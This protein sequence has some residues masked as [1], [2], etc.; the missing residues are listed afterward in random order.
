MYADA[1]ARNVENDT[2]LFLAV[3]SNKLE[4]VK[5][6]AE[7]VNNH[8]NISNV[9]GQ[10]LPLLLSSSIPLSVQNCPHACLHSLP[11]FF[12][13]IYYRPSSRDRHFETAISRPLRM[14]L[15][16]SSPPSRIPCF[17]QPPRLTHPRSPSVNAPVLL[18]SH[19]PFYCAPP[20]FISSL[21]S[22]SFF[23]YRVGRLEYG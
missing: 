10:T 17:F 11:S 2:P 21:P 1:A 16:R 5:L 18:T 14:P 15:L 8:V 12:P 23:I 4:I 6:I 13:H 3:L 19:H 9:E 20:L 7:A 22:I